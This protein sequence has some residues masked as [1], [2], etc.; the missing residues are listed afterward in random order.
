MRKS[1]TIGAVGLSA[2]ALAT[3]AQAQDQ[4]IIVNGLLPARDDTYRTAQVEV[5]PLGARSLLDT[6]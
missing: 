6:P 5:G 4:E 2:M 3:A 1:W